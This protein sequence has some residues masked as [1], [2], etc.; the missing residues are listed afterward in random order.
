MNLTD[1]RKTRKQERV[2]LRSCH[3][4]GR[5][6]VGQ[7]RIV[8]A[9]DWAIRTIERLQPLETAAVE[10]VRANDAV[11]ESLLDPEPDACDSGVAAERLEKATTRFWDIAIDLSE[12]RENDS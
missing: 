6:V 5:G 7:G 10:M 2:I 8:A 4:A 9:L 12:Q 1:L 11:G 3:T